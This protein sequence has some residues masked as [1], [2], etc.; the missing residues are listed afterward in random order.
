[1]LTFG[2]FLCLVLLI[3]GCSTKKV[4]IGKKAIPNEDEYIIKALLSEDEGDYNTSIKIYDFLY[5]KTKKPIYLEKVAEDL[6]RL[7]E[8]DKVISLSHKVCEEKCDKKILKYEIFSLLQQKKYE[9]AKEILL[10]NLNEKDE[11]FYSMMS[12]ILIKEGKLDEALYYLKSLYALHP[13][14]NI[15]L[16]LVDVMIKLKRYNEALAYLRT[17]LNLYGCDYDVCVRLADIYKSLYDYDNLANIYEKLGQ[18]DERY[19]ILA[20]NIYIQNQEYK[21]AERLIKK[22]GLNK[23]YLMLLYAK[24]KEYRKA[25]LVALDLYGKTG[26]LK[27]LL[28]YCEFLYND[29]PT[30]DEIKDII[31]KLK[32]ISAFYKNAYIYNFLGYLEIEYNFNIKEGIKYV[33]KALILDPQ[34]EEYMDSLAWGLYKLHKCEDA[35]EV[36]KNVHIDDEEINYHKKMIKRCL[37]DTR[38][39]N[40]QN[41]RRTSKKKK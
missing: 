19:Y 7:K 29:H 35:Y 12:Y 20:L 30:K 8:Y 16:D 9:K 21:K 31:K 3:T 38:K 41:K 25:A 10:K 33:Q 2:S 22:Y 34:N 14:K 36:I 5:K 39:N 24:M 37:N 6:Y 23:E 26:D 17:H 15:L 18:F 27:Y 4:Q 13:N 32:Y 40:K 11:F 1:M 28:K